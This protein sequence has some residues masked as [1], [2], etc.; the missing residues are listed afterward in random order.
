MVVLSDQS[1]TRDVFQ[2]PDVVDR[3]ARVDV[4]DLEQQCTDI[5]FGS[6]PA[7]KEQRKFF[8]S[9]F[10]GF[11][12]EQSSFENRITDEAA[13]AA[14]EF[15][16][17][18]EQP[19]NPKR[20]LARGTANIICGILLGKRYNYNDIE[21][22]RIH[23]LTKETLRL[24]LAGGLITNI[25]LLKYLMPNVAEKRRLCKM[26]LHQIVSSIIEDHKKRLGT[27]GDKEAGDC[28]DAYILEMNQ[29]RIKGTTRY[30]TD[31]N[32]VA[33]VANL[34]I[35]GT[36]TSAN[37][38]AWS[39]LYM[40]AYPGIQQHIHKEIDSEVGQNK[41]V[42]ASDAP[43]LPYLQATMLEVQRIRPVAPLSA[44]HTNPVETTINGYT[45]PAKT[46]VTANI[47]AIHHDRQVWD[48]P[49]QFRPERFLKEQSGS[50]VV[51]GQEKIMPFS[52]GRRICAG[53]KIA[54]LELFLIFASLLQRFRITLPDDNTVPDF[55]TNDGV[56]SEPHDFQIRAYQR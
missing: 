3:P 43:N 8:L 39:L 18:L 25:P 23:D 35:A 49:E 15:K 11:G 14:D 13:A 16:K 10:R 50:T 21:F 34:F 28:I 30:F 2:G 29:E 26:E 48:H 36:E 53:E 46:V 32:L 47:W 37:T 24:N 52:I 5:V 22:N 38:L 54:R 45:I 17:C 12:V 6:G 31:E 44:P 27:T 20:I 1:I 7:W 55:S 4:T 41:M 42:T 19:F 9:V 40:A 56:T 51:C 33:N